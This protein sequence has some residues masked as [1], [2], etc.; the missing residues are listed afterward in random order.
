MQWKELDV[1]FSLVD[2]LHSKYTLEDVILVCSLFS[3]WV[4]LV[5]AAE[6]FGLPHHVQV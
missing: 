5:E 6:V 4:R 2:E 3:D 1:Q